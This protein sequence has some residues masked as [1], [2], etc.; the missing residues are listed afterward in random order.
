MDEKLAFFRAWVQSHKSDAETL[1]RM[2]LLITEFGLSENKPGFSEQKRNAFYSIIY[3]QVLAS[4]QSKQGAAAGALQ[5]QLLPADMSDW[6]DGYAVDP[7]CGASI[8]GVISQQSEKLRDLYLPVCGIEMA[9]G[10][11]FG[12]RQQ[13]VLCAGNNRTSAWQQPQ[14]CGSDNIMFRNGFS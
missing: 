1:L 4:A 8:C 5:W 2:P 3:D 6:N 13:Q 9:G 14:Q 7:S 12:Q 11:M 10:S